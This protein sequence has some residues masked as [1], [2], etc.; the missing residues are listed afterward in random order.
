M[1]TDI[2][3]G[4]E[5]GVDIAFR[6]GYTA[7][8]Y[9]ALEQHQPFV[10]AVMRVRAE[11]EREG[12]PIRAKAR[13]MT[14]KLMDEVFLKAK[15]SSAP[16]GQ[17]LDA[18]KTMAKIGDLEPKN[19]VAPGASGPAFSVV[20]NIPTMPQQVGKTIEAEDVISFPKFEEKP[21]E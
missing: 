12:H 9:R 8:E 21:D 15:C 1:I 16:L 3:Q 18:V 2:A 10:M 20:I 11:L 19:I 13:W 17:V 5:E 14:D 6:Y 7:S 4:M